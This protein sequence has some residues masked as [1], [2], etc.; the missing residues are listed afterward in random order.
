MKFETKKDKIIGAVQSADRT[1]AKNTSLPI[2]ECILLEAEQSGVTIRSTNLDLGLEIK[3]P[4]KVEETGKVAIQGKVFLAYLNNL[5][6]G[7]M[8]SAHLKDGILH[9]SSQRAKARIKSV[10]L[11][12]FPIIPKVK[13]G[14]EGILDAGEMVLGLKSVAFACGAQSMKPELASVYVYSDGSELVCATTDSFRLAEKRISTNKRIPALS[15]LI[16]YRNVLEIIRFLEQEKG[17]VSVV[18]NQN[19]ITFESKT[20]FISSRVVDGVFPDY[21]QI[22]PKESKTKALVLKKDLM[23]ALKTTVVFSDK[24]SMVSFI[25]NMNDKKLT[26]TTKNNDVGESEYEVEVSGEGSDISLNFNQRYVSDCFGSINTESLSL[27]FNGP[28][29]PLLIR[30][31]GDKSFLYVVMPMN[32]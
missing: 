26:L 17:D 4:A 28:G 7:D 2:L 23:H 3:I 32:K 16:P 29:K 30:G 22:I 24:F 18:Y 1:T 13:D 12:D 14:H 5:S 9:V 21:K 8:L 10:P 20:S 27:E 31:A 6:D 11:D 25:L 19:Q 15:V